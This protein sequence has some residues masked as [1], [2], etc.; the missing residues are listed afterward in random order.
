MLKVAI[1]GNI[2]SG[3]SQVERYLADTYHVYDTDKIAHKILDEIKDFYGYDV[4]TNGKID[5]KKLGRLVF[6]DPE[7][8]KKLEMIIHPQVK[9]ILNN[10]FEKHKN[11]KFVFVSVPLLFEA[12]FDGMFDKIILVTTN[13]K[14]RLERLMKRDNLTK[15]EA[16]SRI[17][18]QISEKEKIKK[19]DFIIENSS[20]FHNLENQTDQI[21]ALLN[22]LF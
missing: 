8:K 3:K 1:T 21:L 17:K 10:I 15:E 22:S 9:E 18:S 12:G 6:S 2:A 13:E 4:F 7:L 5:R 14:T 20:N 16:L 19:S 11:D